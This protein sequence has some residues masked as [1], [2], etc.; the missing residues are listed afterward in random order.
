MTNLRTLILADAPSEFELLLGALR[1]AEYNPDAWH[2]CDRQTFAAGLERQPDVIFADY[3][4]PRFGALDALKLVGGQGLDIPVIIVAGMLGDQK[5]A[6]CI[7]LGAFDILLKDHLTGLGKVIRQAL[8]KRRL[9]QERAR[10]ELA[11]KRA[12]ERHQL[13]FDNAGAGI[14]IT[15]RDGSIVTVNAIGAK[16]L[17]YASPQEM[18][19]SVADAGTH[20]YA[21]PDARNPIWDRL[22]RDGQIRDLLLRWRRKDGSV[23]PISLTIRLLAEEQDGCKLAISI[24]QDMTERLA[25]QADLKNSEA[26]LLLA[27]KASNVGMWD[28]NVANNTVYFSPEWKSQLGYGDEEL[29]NRY[30][31]WQNRLHPD[32]KE[33][34]LAALN[35]CFADPKREYAVEFRLRHKDGSYRYIYTRADLFRDSAGKPV[36]MLGCHVDITERRQ[37][38]RNLSQLAAIV[39]SSNDAIVSRSLNGKTLSWNAAA[40]RMFGWTAQEAIGQP[41]T[42]I[43]PPAGKRES[44]IARVSRGETVEPFESIH[45][46]KDGSIFPS[47]TTLSAIKDEG[48]NVTALANIIRDITE[49]TQQEQ[50]IARLNRIHAMLSGINSAIVL[51]RDRQELFAEACRIAVEH[52]AFRMAWIGLVDAQSKEIKPVAWAGV[53]EGFLGSVRLTTIPGTPEG[54]GVGA[55]AVLTGENTID[56]DIC[57]NPGLDDAR[58]EATIKRG[59]HSAIALPLFVEKA[60][61][62]VL[63]LY[64]EE[65]NFFDENEVKLLNEL[66]ADI[67][68]GLEFITKAENI[69]Y[70]A[71]FDPLT[72]LPNRNL[73]MDRMSQQLSSRHEDRDVVA[74]MLLDVERFRVVN[75]TLGRNGGDELLRQIARRLETKLRGKRCANLA[76]VGADCFG[77]IVRGARDTNELA[78]FI[79][80]ELKDCFGAA[81]LVQGQEVRV[82]AKVGISVVQTDGSS[83]EILYRNAEAALRTAKRTAERFVFYAPEMN[84]R[85]AE[86]LALETRLREALELEQFVLHYQPKI[87]LA[88]GRMC[89]L[90]ALIRWNDPKTGLVPPGM[91][92]PLLEETGMIA[93]VGKWALARALSDYRDWTARGCAVPRIAVNVSAVQLQQKDFVDTVINAVAQAG[94][95]AHALELEITESMIMQDVQATMRKLSILRGLGIQVAM[96]DFGT[97]YSSLSYIARLPINSIKIDRSFVSG[98]VDNPQDK[99]IV[100]TIIALA[101]SLS[102]RVIAEGVETAEQQRL[103]KALGCDEVQG[104]FYS[105]PLPGEALEK[106]WLRPHW[107]PET[108][109]ISGHPVRDRAYAQD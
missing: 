101:R 54:S 49:R 4:L 106:T 98:M 17:G 12:Q 41:I 34:T 100:S 87:E 24:F 42:M 63:M 65:K 94:D 64:S 5:A 52:G 23:I 86:H 97:G 88:S 40:E 109:A 1:R 83:A 39:E 25:A 79:E 75:N 78:H 89:G 90:E 33:K 26:R 2:A 91:F 22:V 18:I 92:I 105:K 28:W 102:L 50:K 59:Y 46:R 47:Q 31:E 68:F 32:D 104:Y 77:M 15:T 45:E 53:E 81:F 60:A 29:P 58:R 73:Y 36:R 7:K 80:E 10:P 56:N 95:L 9:K 44:I 3:N 76:R 8:E 85:V 20:L 43:I 48:G 35:A 72:G 69:D 108:A 96:D 11:L 67:C 70:L 107:T 82:V 84:A 37:A 55:T 57:A 19:N 103:L 38:E 51:I 99:S 66:A 6:E 62:G 30:E 13:V 71:F 93:E 21:D 27:T 14:L 61:T 16:L 74:V